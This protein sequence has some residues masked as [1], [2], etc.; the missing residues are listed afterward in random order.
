MFPEGATPKDGPS[1]G[2][3]MCT[4][5]VSMLTHLPVR[6]DYA[7][8]GEITL[9]GEVLEVGGIK[10]KLLAA[11][12]GGIKNVIIP[13][14]NVKDLKEI[15]DNIKKDLAI[16]PVRWI[17]EV[18]SYALNGYPE[19]LPAKSRRLKAAAMAGN[20]KKLRKGERVRAH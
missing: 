14:E 11:H 6:A 10:E 16:K 13:A 8:T 3:G 2:I 1:A 7:M 15:P 4:A 18:L 9:R 12:R 5:L 20:N 17:D 19:R